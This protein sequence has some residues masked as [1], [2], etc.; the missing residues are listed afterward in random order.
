MLA[1]LAALSPTD[2]VARFT[3]SVAGLTSRDAAMRL[4]RDGPNEI[5]GRGREGWGG[6]CC[7][8]AAIRS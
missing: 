3:T 2:A 7:A 6:R 5:E 4:E 1:E 8:P